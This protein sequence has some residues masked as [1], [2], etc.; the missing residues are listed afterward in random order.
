MRIPLAP[1]RERAGGSISAGMI[2]TVQYEAE[3]VTPDRSRIEELLGQDGLLEQ[4][5]A[6]GR[7][8][9]SAQGD[10]DQVTDAI[11]LMRAVGLEDTARRAA[12]EYLILDRRG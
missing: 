4:L 11:A 10:L 6:L 2:S 5:E 12:L 7:V 8:E 3:L 1:S 9:L